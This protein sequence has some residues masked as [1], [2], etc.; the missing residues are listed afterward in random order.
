MY[1]NEGKI[2]TVPGLEK[3]LDKKKQTS[4]VKK[5]YSGLDPLSLF[6]KFCEI[7]FEC[8]ENKIHLSIVGLLKKKKK[9]Q[10]PNK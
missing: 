1:I 2:Y 8:V 4:K 9:Q 7:Q 6:Q 5:W 10:N 3:L